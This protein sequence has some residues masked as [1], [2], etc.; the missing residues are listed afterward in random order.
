[1]TP[2]E[3]DREATLARLGRLSDQILARTAPI[4]PTDAGP[5]LFFWPGRA[6][7]AIRIVHRAESVLLCTDGL[8]DPWSPELHP[9]RPRVRFDMELALEV[10]NHSLDGT[11][12][13]AIAESW[14]PDL[15]WSLTDWV[16]AE[17]H[18]V[19]GRLIRFDCIT[20]AAPRVLGL[21]ALV[22]RNGYLGVLVGIP[23]GGHDLGMQAVLAPLGGEDAVWLLPVKLLTA[24]EYDWAIA[25]PDSARTVELAEAFL[26]R[27]DRHLSWPDR[28]S[29]LARQPRG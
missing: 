2:L 23:Y 9:D 16:V 14:L 4:R 27:G 25:V 10:P 28:P 21:E 29:V 13:E 24:D 19:K 1:M 18:D 12:D 7:G 3:R 20:L 15:L 8:S 11:D 22:G 6:T 17:R 26:R 5:E